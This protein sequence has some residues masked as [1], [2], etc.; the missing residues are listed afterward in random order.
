[1]ELKSFESY[2]EEDLQTYHCPDVRKIP[3]SRIDPSLLLGFYCKTKAEVK[4]F[5]SETLVC[6][7]F[8]FFQ[9]SNG[10]PV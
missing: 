7:S 3:I 5:L 8:G 2:S 4:E 1:M 6:F 10:N 9:V